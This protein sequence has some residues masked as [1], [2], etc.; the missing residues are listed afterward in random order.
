MDYIIIFYFVVLIACLIYSLI[1]F[2]RDK[3]SYMKVACKR[4]LSTIECLDNDFNNLDM[5]IERLYIGYSNNVP[6]IKKVYPNVVTWLEDIVYRINGGFIYAK[7]LKQY[8]KEIKSA[9]D[10][11]C[12]KY[13]FYE[14]EKYQQEILEDLKKIGNISSESIIVIENLI[15]RVRGEFFRLNMETKKNSKVN[16]LS[17]VLTI[18]SIIITLCSLFLWY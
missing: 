10:K 5:E 9:R 11:L 3:N 15:T 6:S 18:I 14:C 12:E 4:I 1:F 13:P 7:G 16:F 2:I 8:I 17:L